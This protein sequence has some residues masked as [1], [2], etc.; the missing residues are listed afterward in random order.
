MIEGL[1]LLAELDWVKILLIVFASLFGYMLL[2][3]K[4]RIDKDF[5]KFDSSFE[6]WHQKLSKSLD[7]SREKVNETYLNFSREVN[8]LK[9]EIIKLKSEVNNQIQ[10]L[11]LKEIEIKEEFKSSKECILYATKEL[12]IKSR[13]LDDIKNEIGNLYGRVI[14]L[15]G[16]KTLNEE[17]IKDYKRHFEKV[18]EILK[19]QRTEINTLKGAK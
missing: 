1:A 15:E 17:I 2:D 5:N 4:K 14:L 8:D 16:K 18:A 3:Y 13:F 9:N 11:M 12:E 7:D 19:L 10:I 6:N